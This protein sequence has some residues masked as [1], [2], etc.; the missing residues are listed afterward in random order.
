MPQWRGLYYTEADLRLA[1]GGADCPVVLVHGAGG[2]HLH[3]PPPLRRLPGVRTLAVDLP[4]HGRSEG[5]GAQ[6]IEEYARGLAAWAEGLGLPPAL[7]VGHS[8]GGAIVLALVREQPE[9]VAALGLVGTG[10]RLPVNPRLLESTAH[11]AAFPAAVKSIVKWSFAP[12]AS[13]RL[14]ELAARR[15]LETRHTVVHNDFLACDRF[16]ARADLPAIDVPALIVH[17]VLDKMMP[18]SAAFFLREKLPR[19][20]LVTVEAAG[21]MVMLEQ[22][23]MVAQAVRSFWAEVCAG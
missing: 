5:V 11:E 20:R 9:K 14:R 6:R 12:Q 8:M 15:M 17:G 22:P 18:L 1:V 16:D 7:W 21:H 10:A 2:N 13:P 3:W 19:S 4:G 23:E